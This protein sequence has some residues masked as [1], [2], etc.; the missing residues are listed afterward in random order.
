M[1]RLQVW[2]PL[3]VW[4][5]HKK[6]NYKKMAFQKGPKGNDKVFLLLKEKRN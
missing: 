1:G 3:F 5:C 2:I 4:L 6:E